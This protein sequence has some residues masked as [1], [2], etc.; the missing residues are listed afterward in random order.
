MKNNFKSHK[1]ISSLLD[2]FYLGLKHFQFT[3]HFRKLMSALDSN[4]K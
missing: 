1:E 4:F 2:C 3:K